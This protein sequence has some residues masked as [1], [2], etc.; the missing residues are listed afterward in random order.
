MSISGASTRYVVTLGTG[1]TSTSFLFDYL[2]IL[3][4]KVYFNGVLKVYNIDYTITNKTV[5]FTSP[6][7][8]PT[9]VSVI[10]DHPY[11]SGND[12][13]TP[14]QWDALPVNTKFNVFAILLNQIRDKAVL[15]GESDA[16]TDVIALIELALDTSL[17]AVDDALHY[18]QQSLLYSQNSLTHS[19][20]ARDWAIK[21]D[22]V[23]EG[24]EYSS[25][26]WANVSSVIAIPDGS[27]T[28]NKINQ[29][30]DFT[31]NKLHT[32]ASNW[33]TYLGHDPI[34][35]FIALNKTNDTGILLGNDGTNMSQI[36]LCNGTNSSASYIKALPGGR[37]IAVDNTGSSE[38]V[39]M[40]DLINLGGTNDHLT[41]NMIGSNKIF[42]LSGL[43]T[44][45][46]SIGN[47]FARQIQLDELGL[48]GAH[49]ARACYG[50]VSVA[51]ITKTT[52]ARLDLARITGAQ[53]AFVIH[54]DMVFS[55]EV[56]SVKA[57]F[58]LVFAIQ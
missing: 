12:F 43:I 25:K 52:D 16:S 8:A 9:K 31:F 55:A 10:S 7:T 49:F 24:S 19:E 54:I 41:Y 20:K 56:T 36:T 3:N 15:V 48:I 35:G 29:S 18:S 58:S 14:E 32:T 37:L 5:T 13:I 40:S 27:I 38:I 22:G 6:L 1:A 2:D 51:Y 30:Q 57:N 53:N 21:T 17:K 42:T 33:A 23:V 34:N 26:Y 4:V 50:P 11:G 47:S 39:K 44:M 28:N 45:T 46:H